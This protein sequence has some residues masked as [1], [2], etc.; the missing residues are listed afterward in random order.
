M[1]FTK[2][3]IRTDITCPN[4]GEQHIRW[5]LWESKDDN[6]KDECFDCLGCKNVWWKNP[7]IETEPT[8]FLEFHW[9]IAHKLAFLR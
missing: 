3:E 5:R 6:T 2:E 7:P 8:D 4:C 9:S 1:P